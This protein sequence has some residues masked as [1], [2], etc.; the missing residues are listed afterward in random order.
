MSASLKTVVG[1]ATS[2][3][4]KCLV[5]FPPPSRTVPERGE[6]EKAHRAVAI[7]ISI[8]I[9]IAVACAVDT[10]CLTLCR[11]VNLHVASA[12]WINR[13]SRFAGGPCTEPWSLE[14]NAQIREHSKE[15]QNTCLAESLKW[16]VQGTEATY[17]LY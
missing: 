6:G 17:F 1:S 12:S 13:S 16:S 14:N 10:V 8:S 9:R 7:A 11:E 4:P 15:Q 2:P 3:S 5:V